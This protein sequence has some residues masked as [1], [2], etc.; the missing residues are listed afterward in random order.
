MST[1]EP[2]PYGTVFEN[3]LKNTRLM[4]LDP[5][6]MDH[7]AK[8]ELEALDLEQAFAPHHISDRTMAESCRSAVWMVHNY[9]DTSHTICQEIETET[10][11]YWHGILHRREPDYPNS[12]YWFSRVGDHAI[13]PMLKDEAAAIASR[14]DDLPDEVAFLTTQSSWDPLTFI[15]LCEAAH[16]GRL[17]I[18]ALCRRIQQREWELLFDYAYHH[19]IG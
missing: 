3:L 5:G 18:E 13:Y 14:T 6:V 17:P 8:A 12:K 4:P 11:S 1:F 15:D 19:A 16:L 2:A 7:S 10:G 9:L